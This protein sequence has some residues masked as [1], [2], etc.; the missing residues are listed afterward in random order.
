M[1]TNLDVLDSFSID[2]AVNEGIARFRQIDVLLNNAGYGGTTSS[3]AGSWS[4]LQME[5]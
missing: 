5:V 2:H 4:I 3:T 1:V